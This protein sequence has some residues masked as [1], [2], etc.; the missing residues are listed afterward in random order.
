MDNNKLQQIQEHARVITALLYG[1]TAPE[2]LT[3]LEGIEAAV[4]DHVLEHVSPEIGNFLSQQQAAQRVD[5]VSN[6]KVSSDKSVSPKTRRK[7]CKLKHT[8]N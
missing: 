1:E 6:S 7:T 4:R 5:E 8:P 3:S 2:Q